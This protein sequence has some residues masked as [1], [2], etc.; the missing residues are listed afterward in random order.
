[1]SFLVYFPLA[2]PAFFRPLPN[3]LFPAHRPSTSCQA[4]FRPFQAASPVSFEKCVSFATVTRNPD[5]ARAHAASSLFLIR[6]DVAVNALDERA[7]PRLPDGAAE[8]EEGDGEEAHVAKVEAALQEPVHFRLPE[9]VV[10]LQQ[11]MQ[12]SN[13]KET[14]ESKCVSLHTEPTRRNPPSPPLCYLS[15]L[16]S[17]KQ[18]K[19]YRVEEDVA[20]RGAGSEEGDPLPVVVL[21]VED[22]VR[23][24]DGGAHAHDHEDQ[25]DQHHEAVHVVK[26]VVPEAREDE[27]PD[28]KKKEIGGG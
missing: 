18:K 10:H 27:I 9:E 1:M 13:P 12:T 15:R 21:G 22:E 28:L 8:H 20:R 24:D 23:G 4:A 17:R 19:T 7:G 11:T 6:L 25:E 5:S 16:Y 3:P 14:N 26:L 2:T